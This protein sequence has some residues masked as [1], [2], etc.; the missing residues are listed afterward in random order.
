MTAG[1]DPPG[2]LLSTTEIK[3]V[4]P[5]ISQLDRDDRTQAYGLRGKYANG[6]LIAV[7][8]QIIVADVVFGIYGFANAW[9]VP[10]QAMEVWLAATVVQVIGVVLVIT[11]SLFPGDSN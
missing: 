7:S 2:G 9:K 3:E 10:A 4:G 8:A 1:E 6:A 5:P 11:R